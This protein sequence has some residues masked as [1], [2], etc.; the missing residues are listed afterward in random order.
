MI[1][2]NT[3]V[4]LL[5]TYMYTYYVIGKSVKIYNNKNIFFE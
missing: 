4:K 1:F 5:Y 3:H 2:Y